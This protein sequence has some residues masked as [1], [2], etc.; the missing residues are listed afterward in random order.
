M[1]SPTYR[2][3]EKAMTERKQVLCIYEGLARA[4]CPI[5]LGHRQGQERTLAYQFAGDASKGLP[6]GGEWKCFDLSK[7]SHVELRTG[8][9][10][11]GGR[12]SKPQHCIEE[13]DLDIN[14]ESPYEPRRRL[15]P[16]ASAHNPRP[17]QRR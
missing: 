4:V 12:H 3:I 7:M 5:I 1:P 17:R 6:P 13:V 8:P 11:D 15:E 9:W 14:P 10:H 16:N 2:L